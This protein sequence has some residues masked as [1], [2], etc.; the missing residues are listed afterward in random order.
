[1]QRTVM[2]DLLHPP[3]APSPSL[4]RGDGADLH[5]EHPRTL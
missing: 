2:V 5:E 1:M 4:A 3:T